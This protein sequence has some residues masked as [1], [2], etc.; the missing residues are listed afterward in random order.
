ML[1]EVCLLFELTEAVVV[2]LFLIEID[3][4]GAFWWGWRF[5]GG[6]R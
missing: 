6:T 4:L 1:E 3:V 2:A 5:G